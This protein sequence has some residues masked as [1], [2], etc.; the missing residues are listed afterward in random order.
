MKPTTAPTRSTSHH[1]VG[2]NRSTHHSRS[3]TSSNLENSVGAGANPQLLFPSAHRATTPLNQTIDSSDHHSQRTSS[4]LSTSPSLSRPRLIRHL[5]FSTP[6]SSSSCTVNHHHQQQQ[7]QQQQLFKHHKSHPSHRPSTSQ[8]STSIHSLSRSSYNT[9]HQLS[10]PPPLRVGLPVICVARAHQPNHPHQHHRSDSYHYSHAKQLVAIASRTEIRI[11]ELINHHHSLPFEAPR[12]QQHSSFS[13]SLATHTRVETRPSFPSRSLD[14]STTFD[15]RLAIKTNSELGPSYGVSDLGWGYASTTSHL[16]TGCTNGSIVIWDIN[17][18]ITQDP[19]QRHRSL[20]LDHAHNRAINKIT[21]AGPTGHWIASGGQDSLVKIWDVREG[22]RPTMTLTTHTDPVRQL[23]FFPDRTVNPFDLFVLTDSGT[24]SHFDLRQ[25]KSCLTRRVAHASTGVGLDWLSDGY[26]S[27]LASAGADGIVKIWNMADSILPSTAMRTLVVGRSICGMA[28]RPG[29]S[30]Q[31]V[32]TPSSVMADLEQQGYS[33]YERG[34]SSAMSSNYS[35]DLMLNKGLS[36]TGASSVSDVVSESSHMG[37]GRHSEILLWDIRR[38]YVPE[39]IIRGRDGPASGMVWLSAD[40]LLT[41]HKRTSAIVQHDISQSQAKYADELPSQAM[42]VSKQGSLC[43]SLGS[44]KTDSRFNIEEELRSA[45][46]HSID[47][48]QPPRKFEFLALN[49]K[50][51]YHSFERVCEHNANLC[52]RV[53]QPELWQLWM[54]VKLWFTPQVSAA[55]IVAQEMALGSNGNDERAIAMAMRRVL[56]EES[57]DEGEMDYNQS[58]GDLESSCGRRSPSQD[59]ASRQNSTSGSRTCSGDMR[60]KREESLDRS[61]TQSP[62]PKSDQDPGHRPKLSLSGLALPSVLDPGELLRGG[63]SLN[64][65]SSA[66]TPKAQMRSS[67]LSNVTSNPS[68]ESSAEPARRRPAPLRSLAIDCDSPISSPDTEGPRRSI[69]HRGIERTPDGRLN[70]AWRRSM[71]KDRIAAKMHARGASFNELGSL[72]QAIGVG[73]L[74][75]EKKGEDWKNQEEKMAVEIQMR[76]SILELVQKEVEINGNVQLGVYVIGVLKVYHPAHESHDE[77]SNHNSNTI[78]NNRN[79]SRVIGIEKELLEDRFKSW[80]RVY[81]KSLTRHPSLLVVASEIKKKFSCLISKEL[82][83]QSLRILKLNPTCGNCGKVLMN[84]V[85][86]SH[87]LPTI[88][89]NSN[90]QS[91]TMMMMLN[92]HKKKMLLNNHQNQNSNNNSN[93][94]LKCDKCQVSVLKCCFCHE[95][96]KFEPLIWCLKC[97]HGIHSHCLK[98]IKTST[99]CKSAEENG[100]EPLKNPPTNPLEPEAR[101][102]NHLGSRSSDERSALERNPKSFSSSTTTTT[103]TTTVA[104]V[105][106]QLSLGYPSSRPFLQCPSGCGCIGCFYSY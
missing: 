7:Q 87:P 95:S 57:S 60:S 48:L 101:N 5:L 64:R 86:P 46:V 62:L 6:D 104:E 71:S 18:P 26:N 12:R 33:D 19:I 16:A 75:S 22:P 58:G 77:E 43:F 23:R 73:K 53:G 55:L 49:Y 84:S 65:S 24:L 68:L 89:S 102:N 35:D 106:P 56:K 98:K 61:E 45:M 79:D 69:A 13:P 63:Q 88:N 96:I 85:V 105:H 40:L 31:L 80:G 30:T 74:L 25:E 1:Q 92:N 83:D 39:M 100:S 99:T 14:S 47:E 27:M 66:T 28:W 29:Y 82:E 54:A 15:D 17:H 11:L 91:L 67:F 78:N 3:F 4:H 41:T 20:T 97:G 34:P 93:K 44:K 50:F 90:Q 76:E 94:T 21:F 8:P 81:L 51:E 72:I 42:A 59:Q 32:I 103:T 37:G 9:H 70:P 52:R 36:A 10:N 2:Q 38:P